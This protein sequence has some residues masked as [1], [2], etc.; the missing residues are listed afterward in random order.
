MSILSRP[1]PALPITMSLFAN[2]N[3]AASTV[4]WLR[5]INARNSASW[6]ASPPG[7]RHNS[8]WNVT[9]KRDDS[10]STALPRMSSAISTSGIPWTSIAVTE[11]GISK[12]SH[13]SYALCNS[14]N[15]H[16]LCLEESFQ[17]FR[18]QLSSP[19]TLLDASEWASTY[20]GGAIVDAEGTH[21]DLLA[22]AEHASHVAGHGIGAQT[23]DRK[24]TRLNSS[25]RC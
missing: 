14:A 2:R 3:S 20:A 13:Q 16:M 8:G 25:H 4:V 22:Q 21:L 6:A 17:A 15:R 19:A 24:S 10:A 12:R 7:S 9:S 5:T 1:T 11:N 18:T 23:V